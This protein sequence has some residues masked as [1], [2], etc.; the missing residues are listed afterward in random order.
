MRYNQ[1]FV[2]LSF[3]FDRVID[4]LLSGNA[5]SS[6]TAMDQNS[7]INRLYL[8]YSSL[9]AADQP[10]SQVIRPAMP[11]SLHHLIGV[12]IVEFSVASTSQPLTG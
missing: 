5:R 9:G 11:Q 6:R 10:E 7:I 1:D 2:F 8:W 4:C 12:C 3:D